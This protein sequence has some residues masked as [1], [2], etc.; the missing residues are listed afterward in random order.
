MDTA[1]ARNALKSAL[2]DALSGYSVAWPNVNHAGTGVFVEVSFPTADRTGGTLKGNEI[3]RETGRMSAVVVI[4][5]GQGEDGA[6]TITGLIDTAF[7]EGR[8]ITF[9][10][11]VITIT[12]P[13]DI[14]GGYPTEADYRVPTVIRYE[15][16][17]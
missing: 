15:A 7:Y 11:G 4:E 17:A 12:H 1:A 8:Q 10:G 2:S 14:R 9:S 16:N 3:K 5:H 6:Y 13:L